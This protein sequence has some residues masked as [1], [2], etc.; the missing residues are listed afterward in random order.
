MRKYFQLG[1]SYYYLVIQRC[2][3][4]ERKETGSKDQIIYSGKV[5]ITRKLVR[6][7]SNG[8]SL[9]PYFFQIV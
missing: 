3:E 5:A 4:L 9:T 8:K 7:N 1:I 2:R 6:L